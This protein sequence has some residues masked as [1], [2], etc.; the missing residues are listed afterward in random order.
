M[1]EHWARLVKFAEELRLRLPVKKTEFE[2]ILQKLLKLNGFKKSKIIT[3][4]TGGDS[5]DGFS[6]CQKETFCVL[7]EKFKYFP[8]EC[9]EKGVGVV[10]LDFE[11]YLPEVK[12]TNYVGAIRSLDLKNKKKA[13]EITYIKN[14]KVL[15]N[16]TSNIFIVK[17]GILATA[18]RGVL[19]GTI[20]NLIIKLARKKF[21][22]EERVIM[23]KEFREADEVFLTGTYKNIMPIVKIDGKMVSDGKVGKNTKILMKAFAEFVKKY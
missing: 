18:K 11:R 3:V 16:S 4:L 19:A 6:P 15:E 8:K 2:K 1:D 10:T 23:E 22:I 12:L 20:R 14:G 9:Y 21:K 7:I 5:E 13:L 17:N